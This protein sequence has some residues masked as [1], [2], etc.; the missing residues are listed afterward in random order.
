[1][2]NRF[3]IMAGRHLGRP[4]ID[5]LIASIDAMESPDG[6]DRLFKV[7][8]GLGDLRPRTFDVQGK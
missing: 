8:D 6:V 1:M 5:A 3:E 4:S 2:A 7:L